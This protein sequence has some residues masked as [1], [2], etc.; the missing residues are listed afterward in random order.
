M[1]G[2][3]H[4][5]ATSCAI[6]AFFFACSRDSFCFV[7][8][9]SHDHAWD[10]CLSAV[11]AE[12][13]SVVCVV[14]K[15]L[16]SHFMSCR[17]RRMVA[18]RVLT[19]PWQLLL[20]GILSCLLLCAVLASCHSQARDVVTDAEHMVAQL[21]RM[22][23]PLSPSFLSASSCLLLMIRL[24]SPAFSP[25]GC[26]GLASLS[27]SRTHTHTYSLSLSLSFS[28]FFLSLSLCP[29]PPLCVPPCLSL[30]VR[31]RV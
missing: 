2:C 16:P 31:A 14:E 5:A 17:L 27:P 20:L 13:G 30:R 15:L 18:P 23:C 21:Q 19:A 12:K 6:M 3:P 22:G 28:S 7:V 25:H 24:A 29:L 1:A 26:P 11:G 10:S 9:L 4:R 8:V